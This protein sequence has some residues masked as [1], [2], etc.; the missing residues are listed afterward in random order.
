[1]WEAFPYLRKLPALWTRA[2]FLSPAG[3][4]SQEIIQR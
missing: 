1:L 4:V 2:F 3:T